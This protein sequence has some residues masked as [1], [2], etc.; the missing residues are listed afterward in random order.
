[1]GEFRNPIKYVEF[2]ENFMCFNRL[3]TFGDNVSYLTYSQTNTTRTLTEKI[4]FKIAI[5]Y[6]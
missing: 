4:A 3:Q 2:T 1:V 6:L 5:G